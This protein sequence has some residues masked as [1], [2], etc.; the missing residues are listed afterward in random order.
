MKH[1]PN[2]PFS[3]GRRIRELRLRKGLTQID[4]AAGLCTPSMISQVE[5]DRARP[6]YKMLY[7]IS[8]RLD[9]PLE[10]LLV[11]VELNLEVV[12]AYKMA[13]AMV[14][15]KEYRAAIPLLEDLIETP[16]AAVSSVDLYLDLGQCYLH[17]GQ[18]TEAEHKMKQVR[19]LAIMRNDALV[20]VQ[21]LRSLG[22]IEFQRKNYT[23]AL[24]QWQGALEES[25]ALE[26]EDPLLTGQLYVQIGSAYTQL[27]RVEEALGAYLQAVER[28]QGTESVQE[29]SGAYLALADG[30]RK[31]DDFEKASSYAELA[32][33]GYA[34]LEN[35]RMT[36]TLRRMHAVAR[37]QAR[38][39][40]EAMADLVAC[41]EEF[42]RLG[43]GVEEGV[44]WVELA[45]LQV[46]AGDAG[47][48]EEA[49]RRAR[50]LLPEM[51]VYQAWVQ[52]VRGRIA[53]A[54]GDRPEALRR[55]AL[56]A[57]GFRQRE[58]VKEWVET[59][60]AMAGLYEAEGEMTR[61]VQVLREV[62][63]YTGQVLAERGIVL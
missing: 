58:A 59:M 14:L 6:S 40:D 38:L 43:D 25:A 54:A 24:Y 55:F 33:G 17:T 2:T 27:G 23:L 20:N 19:E 11:D 51:H 44:A 22:E 37:G 41:V 36:A 18:L 63:L 56:A 31:V 42:R 47:A 46:V 7:S 49:C 62:T 53:L 34:A 45:R 12:S 9:V 48:A 21:V 16:R 13:R 4:L 10:R 39:V 32:I 29:I 61:A 3:L 15:A 60:Q 52:E 50:A 1:D 57:D 5:S 30:Y 35:L 8:E 28:L 26:R